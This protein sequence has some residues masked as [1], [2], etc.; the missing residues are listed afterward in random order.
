M[1]LHMFSYHNG[2]QSFLEY[3]AYVLILYTDANKPLHNSTAQ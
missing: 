2:Y 3:P 1:S